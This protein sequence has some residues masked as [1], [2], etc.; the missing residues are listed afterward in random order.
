MCV[1]GLA[2]KGFGEKGWHGSHPEVIGVIECCEFGERFAPFG[3]DEVVHVKG[4]VVFPWVGKKEAES[5]LTGLE[6]GVV[7]TESLFGGGHVIKKK[8]LGVKE[9]LEVDG[10]DGCDPSGGQNAGPVGGVKVYFGRTGKEGVGFHGGDLV[11]LKACGDVVGDVGEVDLN[12]SVMD[13]FGFVGERL[14]EEADIA[15]CWLGEGDFEIGAAVH[16]AGDVGE[17]YRKTGGV[18]LSLILEVIEGD[19]RWPSAEGV[20]VGSLEVVV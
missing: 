13:E 9:L 17:L 10:N 2:C 3:D 19:A 15:L 5:G 16:R 20:G 11:K 14:Q 1:S 6:A 8:E 18:E 12:A 7:M 4:A